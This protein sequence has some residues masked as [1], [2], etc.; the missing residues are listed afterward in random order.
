MTGHRFFFNRRKGPDRRLDKDPCKYLPMDL[1]HRKR[2]KSKER[3]APNRTLEQDVE[4][5]LT[6]DTNI[7]LAH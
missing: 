2:R 5:F 6:G 4:A 1:Y 3:R 7:P